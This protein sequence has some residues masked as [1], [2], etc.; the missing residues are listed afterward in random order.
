MEVLFG[1]ASF[2]AWEPFVVDLE[3]YSADVVPFG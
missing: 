1:P 3:L 2:V